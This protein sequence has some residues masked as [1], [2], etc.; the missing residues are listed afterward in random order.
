MVSEIAEWPA[1]RQ[2][3]Y[4]V[5]LLMVQQLRLA[6]ESTDTDDMKPFG[7]EVTCDCLFW[8][9]Y[10]LPCQHIWQQELL[11]GVLKDSDWKLFTFM[12]EDSGMEVYESMTKDFIHSD[13]HGIIGAPE[14]RKLKLREVQDSLRSAYYRI[15]EAA[16]VLEPDTAATVVNTWID[17]LSKVTGPLMQHSVRDLIASE[18]N[19]SFVNV[20][21]LLPE[22]M[23]LDIVEDKQD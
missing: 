21:K 10:Q 17:G 22:S 18:P 12:F 7:E 4:P 16:S 2:L 5:Q 3:L 9:Q 13:V 11:Y 1:L 23:N 8:R 6:K 20:D 15:E 19:L 14:Q